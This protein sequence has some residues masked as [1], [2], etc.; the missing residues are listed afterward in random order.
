[1][2]LSG[3]RALHAFALRDGQTASIRAVATSDAD[4][5][6]RFIRGLSAISRYQRFLMAI[7]E[8]PKDLLLH[9][10]TH[11]LD[12]R[13]VVLVA[14]C[15]D[16]HIVGMAQYVTDNDAR[17]CEFAIV[18]D[19]S[20]QR[21]GLGT[22]MLQLLMRIAA[23]SGA[24]HAHSDV[25]ADNLAM[26]SLAARFGCETRR[27]ALAPYLVWWRSANTSATPEKLLRSRSP[28]ARRTGRVIRGPKRVLARFG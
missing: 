3:A 20:W 27:S 11:P 19:D 6:R 2:R 1:M 24:R 18:I 7:S 28:A 16:A 15:G 9:R 12:R 8:L 10:F 13:E 26:R 25:L 23:S 17:G 22:V 5:V 4:A 14:A 21:Q